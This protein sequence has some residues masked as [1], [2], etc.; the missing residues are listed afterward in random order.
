MLRTYKLQKTFIPTL[1]TTRN[2]KIKNGSEGETPVIMLLPFLE[3]T[4][5]SL[6]DCC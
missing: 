3:N 4:L 5:E 6:L 2:Q 1:V